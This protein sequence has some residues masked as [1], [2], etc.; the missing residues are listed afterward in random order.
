M[1]DNFKSPWKVENGKINSKLLGYDITEE[2]NED[3]DWVK[4][5]QYQE[6]FNKEHKKLKANLANKLATQQ[7]LENF[8][9]Q[10]SSNCI[11]N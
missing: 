4:R 10:F 5:Y 1:A 2:S 8:V 9:T 6:C 3:P 7:I 11:K